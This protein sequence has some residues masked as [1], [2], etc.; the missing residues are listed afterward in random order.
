MMS[1]LKI[2]IF[3]N[4][5]D[6]ILIPILN[7]RRDY[8]FK[9]TKLKNNCYRIVSDDLTLYVSRPKRLYKYKNSIETRLRQLYNKYFIDCIIFKKGDV[10][11][12]CGSN[13]GEVPIAIRYFTN[14]D[15]KVF[16]LEPDPIEYVVLEKNLKKEDIRLN[17][18]LSD[19]SQNAFAKYA[20]DNGDTHLVIEEYK[21]LPDPNSFLVET[22]TLDEVI[23]PYGI[24]RIKLMKIE[25]EGLEPEVILGARNLLKITDFVAVDTGPERN[26]QTTFNQVNALMFKNGFLLVKSNSELSS[27]YANVNNKTLKKLI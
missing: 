2:Y 6:I 4:L 1:R 15:I 12:D 10:V 23:S 19:R 17:F 27:L 5:P 11:I 22:F 16:A 26:G 13:I 20:N 18:F 25:V 9:I 21:R 24:G 8:L 7:L 3:N 14:V